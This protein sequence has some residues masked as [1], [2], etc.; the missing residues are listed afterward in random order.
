ME[1]MTVTAVLLK[2]LKLESIDP[3][4]ELKCHYPAA[5]SFKGGVNVRV[6]G[7]RET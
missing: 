2:T 5:L 1:A 4:Q 6:L 3:T 7:A